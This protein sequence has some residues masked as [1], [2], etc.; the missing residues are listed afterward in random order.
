MSFVRGLI[1][2]PSLD[3][4]RR[5]CWCCSILDIVLALL[6]VVLSEVGGANYCII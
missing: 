1:L 2:S 3:I 5:T 4:A 6:A